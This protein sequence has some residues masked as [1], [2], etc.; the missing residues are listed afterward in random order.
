MARIV[1]VGGSFGG[2]TA[3]LQLKQK[4]RGKHKV[5]VISDYDRFAFLL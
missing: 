1:I 4:L 5:T 2:L 3:A